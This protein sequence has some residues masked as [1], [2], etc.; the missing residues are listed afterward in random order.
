MYTAQWRRVD[1]SAPLLGGHTSEMIQLL[2]A[3]DQRLE[4]LHYVVAETDAMSVLKAEQFDK[5][6][7][8]LH[9]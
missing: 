7:S 9:F 1:Q 3:F 2:K 4:P 8:L 5:V 6:S